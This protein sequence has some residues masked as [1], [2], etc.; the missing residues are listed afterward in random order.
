MEQEEQEKKQSS[1]STVDAVAKTGKA[2]S[3]VAQGAATGGV[4]GAAFAA[5]SE[6]KKYLIPLACLLLI[7]IIIL[8]MLPTII[9]GSILC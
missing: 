6:G 3:K 2:I 1:A 9:F 7:P 5:L 4:H 8:A